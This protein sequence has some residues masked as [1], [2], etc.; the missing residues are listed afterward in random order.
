MYDDRYIKI[1]IRTSAYKVYSKFCGLNVSEH[2]MDSETFKVI[3]I[4]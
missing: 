4:F 3:S 2:D 1:K